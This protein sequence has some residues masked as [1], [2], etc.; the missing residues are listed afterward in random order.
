MYTFINS[1]AKVLP[2]SRCR[3]DFSD[4][5]SSTLSEESVHLNSRNDLIDY[6]NDAHNYVNKK[7][8]K[9]EFTKEECRAKFLSTND[10]EDIHIVY[11]IIFTILIF[12]ILTNIKK[13]NIYF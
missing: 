5:V 12:Y 10:S 4:F 13:K 6:V 7:L 8:G 1:F 3:I 2:C 9:K 11:I